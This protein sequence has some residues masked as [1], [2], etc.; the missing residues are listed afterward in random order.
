MHI[1]TLKTFCD[2]VDTGSFSKA[3]QLNFIS[4]SAVSQQ[5]KALETRYRRPLLE[6]GPR[7]GVTPTDAGR[8]FYQECKAILE[9]FRTLEESIGTSSGTLSGVVRI[10]T[11]YSVG[12]HKLPP[13]VSRFMKAHPRVKVHVEYSRTNKVCEACLTGLVDLGIVALPLPKS[14]LDV[15]PWHA[16]KLVLVCAPDHRLARRRQVSVG[17]LAGEAFIAFE[18]DIPTRK[19][20]DQILKT[21]R[22]AVDIAMEFDNIETIKRSVEVGSGLS[23]LPDTTVVNEVRAGLLRAVDFV[24]GPFTRSVAIVHRRGHVSNA[25]AA[26]FL[27]SLETIA[28][29][30]TRLVP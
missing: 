26:S 22:V 18:R 11:V 7:R 10:A 23:I 9:R 21:H 25:A 19:T 14:N 30:R 17:Q 24:E 8:L 2:L 28:P 5:L 13:Y 3:A 4:Q 27:Q 20:I 15:I 16:E 29:A 6:R 1:E 12:L